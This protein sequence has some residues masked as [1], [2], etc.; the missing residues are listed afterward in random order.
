MGKFYKCAKHKAAK[1]WRDFDV[2]HGAYEMGDTICGKF[3]VGDS[4][5]MNSEWKR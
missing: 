1:E 3:A 4:L 5:Q 2:S